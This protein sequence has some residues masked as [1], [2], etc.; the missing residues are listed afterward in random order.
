MITLNTK[1]LKLICLTYENMCIL[2]D[3]V[4]KFEDI[5]GLKHSKDIDTGDEMAIDICGAYEYFQSLSDKGSLPRESLLWYR[6][7]LI[8]N[9]DDNVIIGGICFKGH[10][11]Q[12]GQ[13]EIGYGIDENYQNRGYAT[14]AVA[15]LIDWSQKQSGVIKV[16]AET[17]KGNV[18]SQRV[19]QKC[20][21]TKYDENEENYYWIIN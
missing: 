12:N 16:T 4:W 18:S 7:W 2:R 21:M 6:Y 13:V 20:G 11:D 15:E 1:R 9:V 3:S 14:E 10:P 19:L 17:E 8:I 5:L